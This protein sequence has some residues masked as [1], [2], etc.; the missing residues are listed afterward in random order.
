[1]ITLSN[2]SKT[3]KKKRVVDNLSF[4]MK[5]GQVFALLG[6]NGAGK[7]TTIKMIL[8]LVAKDE[9]EINIP[10]GERIGYSPE[11]RIF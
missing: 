11:T 9:G 4:S 6:S 5:E 10:E 1:M 8:G 7:S 3:Y 2:L